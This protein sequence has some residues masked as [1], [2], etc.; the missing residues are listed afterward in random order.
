MYAIHEYTARA[1]TIQNQRRFS[2]LIDGSTT[3]DSGAFEL[4]DPHPVR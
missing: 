2:N 4:A 1:Y 3:F